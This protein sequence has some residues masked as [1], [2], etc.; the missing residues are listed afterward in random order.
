M[1]VLLPQL[2]TI[3]A[4]GFSAS[5]TSKTAG[6]SSSSSRTFETAS[7]A[8]ASDS[9]TIATIASPLNRTRSSARTNSS[10]G[11]TPI[12]AKDRVD[13][14]WH[15]RGGQGADEARHALGL[16]QIDPRDPRV[17]H[18]A[19]DHLEVQHAREG[20]V[21]VVPGLPGDVAMSVATTDG[22]ADDVEVRAHRGRPSGLPAIASAAARTARTMGRYPVQRQMLPASACAMSSSLGAGSRSSSALETMTMPGVQ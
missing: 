20:A 7:S 10:S 19:A 11:S 18:G 15:V 13:V 8:A 12:R 4:P 9:A 5:S 22:L 2:V 14:V 16:R 17:M 1:N 6:N 3:G 21:A